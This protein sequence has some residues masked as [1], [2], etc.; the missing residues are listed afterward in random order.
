MR[1]PFAWVKR[2]GNPALAD[3]PASISP[4]VPW[5]GNAVD[6]GSRRLERLIEIGDEVGRI[7]EPYRKAHQPVA[8]AE[9]LPVFRLQPM[10]RGGGGVRDQALAVAEIVG[11]LDQ[12]DRVLE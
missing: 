12:P 8:D 5:K 10:V 7:L 9:Y 2:E 6:R 4:T 3:P 1:M 11:D